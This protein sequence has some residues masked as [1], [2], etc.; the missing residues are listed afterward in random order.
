MTK[1]KS[2][3]IG[4]ITTMLIASP[5][6]AQTTLSDFYNPGTKAGW[7]STDNNYQPYNLQERTS[8]VRATSTALRFEVRYVGDAARDFHNEVK[9]NGAARAGTTKFYGISYHIPSSWVFESNRVIVSQFFSTRNDDLPTPGLGPTGF[10]HIE[11][12]KWFYLVRFTDTSQTDQSD[13]VDLDLGSI[14]KDTYTDFVLQI[15]WSTST[16]GFV[17]IWKGLKGQSLTLV[18]TYNGK[19]IFDTGATDYTFNVGLYNAGWRSKAPASSATA[20]RI[21][22]V[23]EV[24]M[25]DTLDEAKPR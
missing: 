14:T 12:G 8:P 15:K 18:N 9:R 13:G 2:V 24:R 25:G 10:L 6:T 19:T 22:Y 7:S 21:L 17:K 23:D 20:T 11:N 4:C 5:I 16:D 1:A 3:L